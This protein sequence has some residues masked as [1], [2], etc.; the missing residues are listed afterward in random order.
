VS[1]KNP[2]VGTSQGCFSL[3]EVNVNVQTNAKIETIF[4]I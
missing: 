1:V 2:F 3:Q 4:F